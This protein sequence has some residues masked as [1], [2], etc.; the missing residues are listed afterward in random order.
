MQNWTKRIVCLA[1]LF[2]TVCALA[3]AQMKLTYKTIDYPGAVSTQAWSINDFGI[4]V[5]RYRDASTSYGFL[6]KDGRFTTITIPGASYV[7]A[8]GIN[9]LGDIVGEYVDV[10]GD[11][12]GFM[13]HRGV[14]T[15]I[16]V[17]GIGSTIVR[18]I[19]DYGMVSG[20]YYDAYDAPHAFTWLKGLATTVDLPG[21]LVLSPGF[22]VNLN[23]AGTLVGCADDPPI[24]ATHA[25]LR[26]NGVFM[27]FNFFDP[28][29]FASASGISNTG[30][31]VGGYAT[32]GGEG[33]GVLFDQGTIQYFD[34][35]GAHS[36]D[37]R[38]INIF[39]T[40]VGFYR[41]QDGN[42]HGFLAR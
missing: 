19:N 40:I 33:H 6:Y 39:R 42:M 1:F 12:H 27:T 15:N 41:D 16:D 9:N 11:F 10:N 36:T 28:M 38:G 35:L 29:E 21:S 31:I 22:Y 30:A 3:Q 18:G 32:I 26:N 14:V 17:A 8:R 13:L 37:A 20:V 34:V 23:N 25:F 2:S 5:G 7:F 24:E 4:V